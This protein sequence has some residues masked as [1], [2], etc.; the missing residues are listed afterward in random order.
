M[1]FNFDDFKEKVKETFD[2]VADTTK[3]V[4]S[5]T[6]DKAKTMSRIAK[7]SMDINGE[8]EAIKKAYL[9]IGKLYY[10][11]HKDDP[12]GFFVQLCDEIT[13]AMQSISDKETEIAELKTTSNPEDGIEVEF[14]EIISETEE[15]AEAE[16]NCGCEAKDKAQAVAEDIKEA[17]KEVAE[18]IKE[19]VEEIVEDIKD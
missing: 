15:E 12:D 6:A 2:V 14:E 10:E 1:G 3:D 17:A 8:K 19:T 13:I 11:T 4:A 7:L 9:E 16:C 5:R 18:E